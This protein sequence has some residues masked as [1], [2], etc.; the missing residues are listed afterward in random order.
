[1]PGVRGG[2]VGVHERAARAGPAGG[3]PEPPPRIERVV[4]REAPPGE[5]GQRVGEAGARL[6][7]RVERRP[8]G[9]HG[10]PE[11]ARRRGDEAGGGGQEEEGAGGGGGGGEEEEGQGGRGGGGEESEPPPDPP[12]VVGD[13][14]ARD[15]LP[16]PRV[17]GQPQRRRRRREGPGGN[18]RRASSAILG[19]SLSLQVGGW[20][21]PVRTGSA[22]DVAPDNG[23]D[24]GDRDA[25]VSLREISGGERNGGT[26]SDEDDGECGYEDF[27]RDRRRSARDD[28]APAAASL[29]RSRRSAGGDGRGGRLPPE[30]A[31]T[32]T[33][34]PRTGAA[35]PTP[36]RG[37]RPR[38]T[39]G[40]GDGA[41]CPA[42]S[43]SG[44]GRLR[45]TTT[46]PRTG[47]R[48]AGPG[49]PGT[50]PAGP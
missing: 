8:R 49:G 17:E 35:L 36:A 20:W 24:G 43:S 9:G 2:R 30:T 6:G 41:T 26:H 19:R 25:E 34:T 7:Q 44:D 16:L 40:R 5:P 13:G 18:G 39:A 38:T 31:R 4:E 21:N 48:S 12:G 11:E 15:Q 10:E 28:G 32:E 46:P 22:Q 29:R 42:R 23:V 45:P 50:G 47:R 33:P 14:P 27:P 37:G 3:R 1:E